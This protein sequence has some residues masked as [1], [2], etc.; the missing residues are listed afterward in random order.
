MTITF[1]MFLQAL[2]YWLAC[3]L[4][5]EMTIAADCTSLNEII[6]IIYVFLFCPRYPQYVN[7]KQLPSADQNTILEEFKLLT[8]DITELYSD[9]T[10]FSIDQLA[11]KFLQRLTSY[12]FFMICREWACQDPEMCM[13][14]TTAY[15]SFQMVLANDFNFLQNE[16]CIFAR[17]SFFINLKYIL[18]FKKNCD[19]VNCLINYCFLNLFVYECVWFIIYRL[20]QFIKL[21][22]SLV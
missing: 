20:Y 15:T 18:L 19:T 11:T 10:L 16:S 21:I 4:L 12:L 13:S 17:W 5:K 6:L 14:A 3:R 1:I 9:Y 22:L 7:F 2:I 8:G